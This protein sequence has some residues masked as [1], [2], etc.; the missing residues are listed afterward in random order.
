M[1]HATQ[2]IDRIASGDA[3]AADELVPL[4]YAELRQLASRWLA[5]DP[6]GF[7]LD[8]T[9]LVHEAYLKLVGSDKEWDGTVHFFAAAAE[10]MRR[11]LVERARRKGRFKRGGHF[12]RR[13]WNDA[14]AGSSPTPEEIVLVSDLLDHFAEKYP[15]EA[16]IAKM[17][18]FAGFTISEAARMLGV[19]ST[20]AHRHW[21]FAKTWIFRELKKSG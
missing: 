15:M 10:A 6:A 18:Y 19:P 11:I 8:T 3:A 4:V 14:A 7:S 16:E 21:T 1:S 5:G 9:D 13:E 17:R 2:I 20:T 12:I